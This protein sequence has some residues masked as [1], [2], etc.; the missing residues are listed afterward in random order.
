MSVQLMQMHFALKRGNLKLLSGKKER[1]NWKRTADNKIWQSE[2]L[3]QTHLSDASAA[4]K[5]RAETL[6]H[7]CIRELQKFS[8]Q[9]Y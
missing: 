4:R 2:K 8:R 7:L 9:C 6:F 1:K 3:F 5:I